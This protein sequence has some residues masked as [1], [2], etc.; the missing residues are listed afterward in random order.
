MARVTRPMIACVGGAL[1]SLLLV[2][3][4]SSPTHAALEPEPSAAEGRCTT[5]REALFTVLYWLQPER[6]DRNKAAACLDRTG[7][8]DPEVDAARRVVALKAHLDQSGAWVR[9]EEIPDAAD[10]RDASGENRFRVYP[11]KVKDL[12]LVKIRGRWL[13][14]QASLAAVAH[15]EPEAKPARPESG[16]AASMPDWLRGDVFGVE[17]WQLLF[18]AL[19]VI[20]G[21]I[22]RK[23]V[24]HIIVTWVRRVTK[25]LAFGW[26]DQ[27]A[28][29]AD[30]PIGTLVIAAVLAV[31]I[32][33]L[34][35]PDT[36]E[37]ILQLA[38]RSLAAYSV[39]WLCY[40]LVDVVSDVMEERAARTTSK[41]DD[42]LVPII[43]KSLKVFFVVVGAIFILQNLDVDVGSL[44]AGLGLGGLAFALA[45]K[46]TVANF[47]GSVMIFVDK[48]FQIGDWI[49]MSGDIEGTVEEVGFRTSRIRT[50]YNSVITVPNANVTNTPI[51]NLGARRYRRYR[52]MLGLTYDTPPEKIEAFCEECRRQGTSLAALETAEKKGM[53]TGI[54]VAHPF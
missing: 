47:F 25:R 43:R 3:A 34:S 26:V 37:F 28:A 10:H 19:L 8:P 40:R 4:L 33:L 24:I 31:G 49:K 16:L 36:F 30:K 54:R 17:A 12:E 2:I 14:S 11:D 29:R 1:S 50:F 5:P 7:L 18:L 39:V 15:L 21:I 46:D 23:L 48:P 9:W 53:D 35:L 51:D 27:V 13:V 32:P 52:A 44:L 45:A 22:L 41:L 38:T 20:L 6:L 42:Q